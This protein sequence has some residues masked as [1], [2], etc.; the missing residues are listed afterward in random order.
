MKLWR[1]RHG[2]L[3]NSQD[4]P[5]QLV[6]GFPDFCNSSL[7]RHLRG[8]RQ[9]LN[10]LQLFQCWTM[11]L[12][13]VKPPFSVLLEMVIDGLPYVMDD[14]S[15]GGG[16]TGGVPGAGH[17]VGARQPGGEAT[18]GVTEPVS[19]PGAGRGASAPGQ[20]S[21]EHATHNVKLAPCAPLPAPT[22][23]RW[24]LE[25]PCA[26]DST[27]AVAWHGERDKCMTLALVPSAAAAGQ[28]HPEPG[29]GWL[30][31]AR[32][33]GLRGLHRGSGCTLAY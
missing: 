23:H 12:V 29:R 15:A 24:S 9:A 21:R 1:V 18:G 31:K 22:K 30:G 6:R 25:T 32:R 27:V 4:H 16:A 14:M 13:N 2:S 8:P 7:T 20:G 17:P 5:F 28:A 19:R 33:A 26:R 3:R 10:F 11:P